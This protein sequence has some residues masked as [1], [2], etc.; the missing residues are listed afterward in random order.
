MLLWQTQTMM[1]LSFAK[2]IAE[3]EEDGG[4]VEVVISQ[5]GE[6]APVKLD[7]KWLNPHTYTFIA[8]GIATN[9]TVIFGLFLVL[10]VVNL[11][12]V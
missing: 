9:N 3:S 1:T 12:A 6:D 5:T 7:A 11:Y 4:N 8:P 2:P 10:F